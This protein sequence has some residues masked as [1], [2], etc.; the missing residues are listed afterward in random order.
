MTTER[1]RTIRFYSGLVIALVGLICAIV[2]MRAHDH[3]LT[4]TGF[5]VALVGAGIVPVEKIGEVLKR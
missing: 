1:R 2:G 4:Y 5:L 3:G